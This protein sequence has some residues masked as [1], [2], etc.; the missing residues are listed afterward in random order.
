VPSSSVIKIYIVRTAFDLLESMGSLSFASSPKD[1]ELSTHLDTFLHLGPCI[2]SPRPRRCG[3]GSDRPWAG[4]R[5]TYTKFSP[6]L[7]HRK[8]VHT[9]ESKK[10]K[11]LIFLHQTSLHRVKKTRCEL[12]AAAGGVLLLTVLVAS[13][14]DHREFR[15]G[16]S[17]PTPRRPL[18]SVGRWWCLDPGF[19]WLVS[20]TYHLKLKST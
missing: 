16:V 3:L 8:P 5:F 18:L 6:M 20:T 13:G 4:G 12:G 1:V 9:L 14:A 15:A 17:D 7:G 19:V 10:T 2:R 11:T